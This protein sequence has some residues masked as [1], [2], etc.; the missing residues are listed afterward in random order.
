MSMGVTTHLEMTRNAT[1]SNALS[2]SEW[3]TMFA[4][5][6]L[7][8]RRML[9]RMMHPEATRNATKPGVQLTNES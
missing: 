4:Q 5:N 3:S 7:L 9:L 8:E 6:V 2:M 1:Q